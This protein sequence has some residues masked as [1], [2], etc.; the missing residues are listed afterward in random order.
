MENLF[1]GKATLTINELNE[2]GLR[3]DN[4]WIY[5]SYTDGV[6]LSYVMDICDEYVSIERWCSV[7][8]TTVGRKTGLKDKDGTEIWEGDIVVHSSETEQ[9]GEILLHKN[10]GEIK[11]DKGMT[12]FIGTTT[13][14]Y[15]G[16]ETVQKSKF[17]FLS[18]DIYNVIGN[19]H[20]NPELLEVTP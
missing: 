2:K 18:P 8:P 7:D 14:T 9:F 6:I 12:Y 20:E 19:I 10:V 3:H 13:Q 17:L 5:G 15:K 11:I 4:G 16:E 1:R